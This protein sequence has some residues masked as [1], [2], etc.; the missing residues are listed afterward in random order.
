MIKTKLARFFGKKQ[1]L[2]RPARASKISIPPHP[3]RRRVPFRWRFSRDETDVK[4]PRHRHPS[5]VQRKP[6]R[7]ARVRPKKKIIHW[8]DRAAKITIESKPIHRSIAR[9]VRPAF[10]RR[11]V[12]THHRRERPRRRPPPRYQT[13][14]VRTLGTALDDRWE[15]PRVEPRGHPRRGLEAL[16]RWRSTGCFRRTI[17]A[18]SRSSF[19]LRR[20]S[21]SV[22]CEGSSVRR[23]R[24]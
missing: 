17:A 12:P 8:G 21:W 20:T 1:L 3:R 14:R 2:K 4:P 23:A 22:D 15:S 7:R 6:A 16:V 9:R 11:R 5:N 18:S 10:V 24:V 13:P 19:R